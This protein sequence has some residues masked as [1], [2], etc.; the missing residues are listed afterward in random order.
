MRRNRLAYFRGKDVVPKA[1]AAGPIFVVQPG[2]VT[3]RAVGLTARPVRAIS[4][5]VMEIVTGATVF[6]SENPSLK[7]DVWKPERP[8]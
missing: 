4:S 2:L 7:P 5:V 8:A 1:N 3:V 6:L